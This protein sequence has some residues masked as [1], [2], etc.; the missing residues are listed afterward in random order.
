M[1]CKIIDNNEVIFETKIFAGSGDQAK[2]IV[3]NWK[4]NAEKL[5]PEILNL[6]IKKRVEEKKIKEESK[7]EVKKKSNKK[8]NNKAKK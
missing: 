8:S 6:L 1:V 2:E 4:E 7:K 3:D 5:Y